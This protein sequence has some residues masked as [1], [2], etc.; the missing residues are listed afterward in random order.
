MNEYD[1]TH[2]INTPQ[3]LDEIA[4]AGL[5]SPSTVD[6][7]GTAV[8]IFYASPLTSD[9]QSSLS[10]VVANH[11][12]N[13]AYVTLSVQADISTLTGYL[14][15]SNPTIANAARAVMLANIAPRLPDGLIATI[16]AQ[17]HAATG[18]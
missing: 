17:I 6:S 8:Q 18:A 13:P 4:I 11:M 1:F 12:A 15:N 10:T 14:N 2:I 9:Q 3:L 7:A 5:P 16:N